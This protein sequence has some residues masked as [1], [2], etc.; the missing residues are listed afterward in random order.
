L[1]E[2]EPKTTFLVPALAV[3]ELRERLKEPNADNEPTYYTVRGAVLYIADKL[4]KEFKMDNP[5]QA[6]GAVRGKAPLRH[7][8]VRT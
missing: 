4:R 8:S 2:K 7:N 6:A 1:A 3:K 5:E